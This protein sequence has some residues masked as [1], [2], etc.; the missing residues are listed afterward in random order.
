MY[1]YLARTSLGRRSVALLVLLSTPARARIVAAD[2]RLVAPHR[3]GRRVVAADAR[4]QLRA[5]RPE[6]AGLRRSSAAA[7]HD[8]LYFRRR[9]VGQ[10]QRRRPASRAS[11]RRRPGWVAHARAQ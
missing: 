6:L 10:D 2:L 3:P 9:R 4:R 5:R 1:T 8:W 7:P 11:R